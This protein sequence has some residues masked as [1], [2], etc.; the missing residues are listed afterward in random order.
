MI[1]AAAELFL[2][3]GFEGTS[4]SDVVKRS[5]G[6]LSTLY[7]WFGSKEGLFE[8]I[9][10]EVSASLLEMLDAP[11]FEARPLAEA[12]QALGERVLQMMLSPNSV[13]WYRMGI[14]EGHKF[15]ELRAALLR[16][17]PQRINERLASF[18]AIQAAAGRLEMEDPAI[19]AVH[20]F[21]LI[22]SETHLAAVCGEP[23]E[24]SPD[25]VAL[26]VG[27]AVQVFLCGYAA[28]ALGQGCTA[29]LG[30][31]DPRPKRRTRR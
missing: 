24:I 7:A 19:A 20:F 17:G 21:A 8:A 26:Q 12:L 14:A 5:G 29:E 9:V 25:D 18:L 10:G 4:V 6:S 28:P 13:R 15:P 1:E 16:T 2:E 23:M 27:R 30:L 22:K 31:G 11:D 3:R